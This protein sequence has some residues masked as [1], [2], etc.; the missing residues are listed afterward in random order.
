[1]IGTPD[2]L[3]KVIKDVLRQERRLRHGASASCT[4]GPIPRTRCAAGTWSRATSSPRSTA[5][6][7]SCAKSQKFLIENRDVFERARPGD[8]GQDHGERGRRRGAQGHRIAALRRRQRRPAQAP[9][10]EGGAGEE[11]Q[12]AGG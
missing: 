9:Q 2:D 11:G 8:H 6:S 5:T 7:P 12:A 4:T 10:G 1:M 3:V